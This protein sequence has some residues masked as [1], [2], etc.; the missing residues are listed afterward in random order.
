VQPEIRRPRTLSLAGKRVLLLDDN[1]A[2]LLV[3]KQFLA[4]WLCV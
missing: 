2:S 1:Q 3:I 4:L